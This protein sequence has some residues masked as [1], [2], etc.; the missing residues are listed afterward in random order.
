VCSNRKYGK[1]DEY[2]ID[3]KFIT[4]KVK[5]IFWRIN[6]LDLDTVLEQKISR[7]P[8]NKIVIM[9]R[10]GLGNQL[11]MIMDLQKYFRKNLKKKGRKT[12]NL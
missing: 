9:E 3:L 6:Y 5:D 12:Y 11:I 10:G 2:M 8:N 7:N 4:Q 1:P